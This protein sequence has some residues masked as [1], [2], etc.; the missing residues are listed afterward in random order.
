MGL[1][2][3]F[4]ETF[5]DAFGWDWTADARADT[6][7]VVT[8]VRLH[9]GMTAHSRLEKSFPEHLCCFIFRIVN[10]GKLGT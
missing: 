6:S 1:F 4:L 8:L 5:L 2:A 10:I 7:T 3:H 9:F